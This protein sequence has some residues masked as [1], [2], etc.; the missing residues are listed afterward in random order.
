MAGDAPREGELV[1]CSITKVKEN[2]A[3][4]VLD[5]YPGREGFIFIGEVASG[6]VKNIRNHLRDGQRV[7]CKVLRTRKDGSSLELSL[8]AVSEERRR[9][10]L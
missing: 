9:E 5:E 10:T 7:V 1:V 8:K 2:G 6:W 3:Y 4:S